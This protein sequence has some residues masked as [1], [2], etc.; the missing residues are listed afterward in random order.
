MGSFDFCCSG[1]DLNLAA[2]YA[3]GLQFACVKLPYRA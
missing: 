2:G 1:L 3:G